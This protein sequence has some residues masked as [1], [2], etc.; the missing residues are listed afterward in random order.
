MEDQ[1]DVV[2]RVSPTRSKDIYS[3]LLIHNAGPWTC[4]HGRQSP[5]IAIYPYRTYCSPYTI[6][7]TVHRPP[8][9]RLNYKNGPNWP[10]P[11]CTTV[12]DPPR[13][14][15]STFHSQIRISWE[16]EKYYQFS[17]FWGSVSDWTDISDIRLISV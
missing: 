5:D 7:H 8:T 12:L 14:Q 10:Y 9:A 2:I 16:F 3:D 1:D 13:L 6:H 17:R 15:T 11:W 4:W